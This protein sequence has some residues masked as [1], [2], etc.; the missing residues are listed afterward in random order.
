MW[1]PCIVLTGSAAVMS[2]TTVTSPFCSVKVALPLATAPARLVLVIDAYALKTSAGAE[3]ATALSM[4]ST[5]VLES[6]RS[7]VPVSGS[8]VAGVSEALSEHP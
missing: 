3:S 1:S 7:I 4:G 2:T 8:F 6:T 5:G